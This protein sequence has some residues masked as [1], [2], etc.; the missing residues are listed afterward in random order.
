[1]ESDSQ[2][3]HVQIT[4]SLNQE[5]TEKRAHAVSRG[6]ATAHPVLA[7]RA[8]GARLWDAE[9]NEYLDFTS[10]IGVMNVGYS[11]PRVVRA[12]EEQLKRFTHT[13][14]QVVMY[15][16]Y[17]ELA[18][19]LNALIG[20]TLS[21]NA[22]DAKTIF[23]TTGVEAVE[24][25]VKIA[26][27][28][29]NRPAV[30]AFQGGFHG[31]TL[32]GM[33]LTASGHTLRQ[34]FGPF[35][36]EVNHI[37]FPHEYRGL[38]VE[39]SMAALAELFET[40]VEPDRVAAVL[41]EPQQGE[42]GFIPAP[43]AF[44]RQLRRV[45]EQHGMVLIVDEIQSGFG[46]TGKMFAY[47]HSGIQPDLVTTAKS[48]AAG[49]PLSAVTGKPTIMDAPAPGGLGGTYAGNPLACAA[50]LAVLEVIEKENLVERAAEIGEQLREGLLKLQTG[51][52]QIGD[53]RGLGA[54]LAIEFV[55]DRAGKE[56]D[57]A[58]AHQVIERAREHGLILLKCGPHKNLIRFLPPLV[59][60]SAEIERGLAILAKALLEA[61]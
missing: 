49:L 55:R 25:A 60:S 45:T 31:R 42:G 21:G 3:G 52:P 37:P 43:P 53:V 8:E 1:M 33:T 6:V 50:G 39:Q 10:G 5:W 20:P 46:R 14:F 61:S 57:A 47:E 44:L 16:P 51:F 27:A 32:L 13:C 56:P 9:G 59:T 23:L 19:R 15:E 34:N 7:A 17:I 18:D 28:H 26:R 54:M 40:R 2:G 38:T 24:N 29:T 22:G 35:A 48:L 12:V 4:K 36:P 30:I 41:V 58:L 11:H